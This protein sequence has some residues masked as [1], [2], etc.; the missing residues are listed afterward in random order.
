MADT[1]TTNLGLTNPEVGASTDSWGTK[2]NTD[3]DSID[4]LF[5]AGPVLKVA[6]GGT[7]VATLTGIV[8]A[9]GTSAFAAATAGTDYVAPGGALGT[10]S[11]GTLT[12]ATGLPISTGVSGLAS[13]VATFLATPS[14]SNLAAVLTDETGSGAN[15]FATSP[16]LVTPALGTPSSGTLSSCTVDGT[17]PVGFRNIPNSGAKT[18][19]Y[20]LVASDVGKFIELGTSGTVVVP[21]SVF[22][23]GDVI[24][25]FNNTSGSISCTCSAVTDVYKGG[26]DTDISSFSITTRGVATV[27]FITTTRAVVTGN[28]V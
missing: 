17:N 15:V 9:S 21:A 25:I 2:I 1:T 8:K 24:S 6:K 23:A 27:L 12:N 20:T 28:L 5:D 16:T 4:A 11:S 26:T 19:S 13:N 14:S 10:P 18:S 22:A 3:L 7:G